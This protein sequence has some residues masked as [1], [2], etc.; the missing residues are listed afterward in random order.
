MTTFLTELADGIFL[1]VWEG[2]VTLEDIR[3][4]ML[5]VF[6]QA[7]RVVLDVSAI[8][9]ASFHLIAAGS[10]AHRRLTNLQH[11]YIVY[12]PVLRSLA[13]LL[14]ESTLKTEYSLHLSRDE[15]VKLALAG[16]GG[17]AVPP[18]DDVPG[19]NGPA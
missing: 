10:V 14:V 11:V 17:V 13:E 3:A 2:H 12:R 19:L 5:P 4:S 7:R 15:A 9:L 1:Y 6:Y 18:G 8:D 16:G